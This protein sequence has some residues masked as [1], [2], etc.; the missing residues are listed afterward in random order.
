MIP[1]LISLSRVFLIIPIIYCIIIGSIY[2]GLALFIVAGLTDFL[3]GFVARY[4]DKES[5]LG[6]NLDLLADKL[7]VCILLI[8]IS[9]H[10]DN[11]IVLICTAL[12]VSREIT[13][14][15]L[16][17]YF[18]ILGINNK[19]KVNLLGKVKTFIQIFSIGFCILWLESSMKYLAETFVISATFISWISLLNYLRND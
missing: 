8:F 15:S 9:F 13:A 6:A 16:R 1:N 11:L 14:T 5:I 19:M 17:H 18:M 10:F 3:D 12:I 2:T 7:F 4:L